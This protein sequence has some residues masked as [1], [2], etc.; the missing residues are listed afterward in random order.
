MRGWTG[1]EGEK[2]LGPGGTV[3]DTAP[4]I[5]HLRLVRDASLALKAAGAAGDCHSVTDA[6]PRAIAATLAA[7]LEEWI[8]LADFPRLR[9]RLLETLLLAEREREG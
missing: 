1:L 7:T 2:E 3:E 6:S 4:R 8:R 9:R 5:K